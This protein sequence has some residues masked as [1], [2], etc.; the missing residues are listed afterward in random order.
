MT[1]IFVRQPSVFP[2]LAFAQS[3]YLCSRNTL[4]DQK[5]YYSDEDLLHLGP[6]R[7]GTSLLNIHWVSLNIYRPID[8]VSNN[9]PKFKPV[10]INKQQ[11]CLGYECK[12]RHCFF[13]GLMFLLAR[14]PN[15]FCPL[16]FN[17]QE[18]DMVWGRIRWLDGDCL[19]MYHCHIRVMDNRLLSALIVKPTVRLQ[20]C[21]HEF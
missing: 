20:I 1:S 12:G 13:Q 3:E 9:V 17:D 4:F 19:L 5:F 14:T 8:R 11:V 6:K 10:V 18:G 7:Y 21:L 16:H 2:I 15:V